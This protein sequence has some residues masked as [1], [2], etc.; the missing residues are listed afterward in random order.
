MTKV[1]VTGANGFI[2]RHLCAHLAQRGWDVRAVVR[3]DNADRSIENYASVHY[4][5]D[6]TNGEQWVKVLHNA[7]VVVHLA[8]RV[9]VMKDSAVSAAEEYRRVNT[10]G[11]AMLARLAAQQ[12]VTRFVFLSTIKVNGERTL[13]KPFLESDAP[14]PRD[15]YSISKWEAEQRLVEIASNTGMEV[16]ALRPPLLYGPGVKGNFLRLM[17]LVRRRVP[18]P[19][20]SVTNLRSFLYVGNLLSVV[21]KVLSASVSKAETF[22]VSDDHDISTPQLI[23]MLAAAMN[24]EARLLRCPLPMLMSL[25]KIAGKADEVRRMVESLSIDCSRIKQQ[26]HWAPPFTVE[27]GIKDTVRWFLE[28]H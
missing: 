24:V 28:T 15:E 21:E 4:I 8:A 2:G 23:R 16:I 5:T 26:L 13:F 18:L 19:L 12:G 14:M 6:V 10:T 3:I 25:A 17:N 11:T 20:A 27:H 9:H 7:D 1:L 22:L